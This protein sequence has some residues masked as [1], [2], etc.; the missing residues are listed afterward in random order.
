MKLASRKNI[1]NKLISGLNSDKFKIIFGDQRG[2]VLH[3]EYIRYNFNIL[4]LYNNR[5]SNMDKNLL[6]GYLDRINTFQEN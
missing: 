3:K 6:H 1:I 2:E 4:K 5:L